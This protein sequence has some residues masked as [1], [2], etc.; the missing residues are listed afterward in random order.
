ML[1]LLNGATKTGFIH[2]YVSQ[3]AYNFFFSIK[4]IKYLSVVK[5]GLNIQ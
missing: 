5:Y 2:K 3:I 1:Y 4:T